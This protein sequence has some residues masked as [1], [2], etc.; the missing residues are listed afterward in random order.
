MAWQNIGNKTSEQ[1]KQGPWL[2]T[3]EILPSYVEDYNKLNH[4]KDPY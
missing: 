3:D 4:D 2:F 1:W